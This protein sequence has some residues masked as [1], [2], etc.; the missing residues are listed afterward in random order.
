MNP[1]GG[2]GPAPPTVVNTSQAL[3]PLCPHSWPW[4]CLLSPL[5][6]LGSP[7]DA[8]YSLGTWSPFLSEITFEFLHQGPSSQK[9]V[10]LKTYG[11]LDPMYPRNKWVIGALRQSLLLRHGWSGGDCW[12]FGERVSSLF[13]LTPIGKSFSG[14]RITEGKHYFMILCLPVPEEGVSP[15]PSLSPWLPLNHKLYECKAGLTCQFTMVS[16]SHSITDSAL[17]LGCRPICS[18]SWRGEGGAEMGRQ[19]AWQ[20]PPLR[21][22]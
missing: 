18:P 20:S 11:T 4:L 9:V 6:P 8:V 7:K 14:E 19:N 12:L 3:W 16:K 2:W 22:C 5:F 1:A 21:Q 17:R 10:E 13:S 15:V